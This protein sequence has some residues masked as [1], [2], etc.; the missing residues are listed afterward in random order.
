MLVTPAVHLKRRVPL[1]GVCQE[2][3]NA[4]CHCKYHLHHL[5]YQEECI[6][7]LAYHQ[8]TWYCTRIILW[9]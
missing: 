1:W 7:K 8:A 4:V 3:K 9:T 5:F 2:Q 6:T